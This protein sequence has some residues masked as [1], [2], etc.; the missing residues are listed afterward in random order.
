MIQEVRESSTDSISEGLKMFLYNN[1][2]RFEK[3]NFLQTNGTVTEVQR[4][5]WLVVVIGT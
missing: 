4:L 5:F 2:S 3:V 1:N